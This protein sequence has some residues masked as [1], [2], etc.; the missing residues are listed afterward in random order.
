MELLLSTVVDPIITVCMPVYNNE[1]YFTE[2]IES[3]LSQG[4]KEIQIIVA[5]DASTDRT[6]KLAKEY[7]E[8]YPEIIDL[9][10]HEK[11]QGVVGNVDSIYPYIR[12]KYICWFAGDDSFLPGKLQKQLEFMESNQE[13]VMCYHDMFTQNRETGYRYR[14][15]DPLIGVKAYSGQVAGM[16]IIGP[17]F[18]PTMS[19]MIRRQGTEQIKHRKEVGILNDWLYL[20]ELA[21]SGP[22]WQLDEPLGIYYKHGDSV[23]T[24]MICS[25]EHAESLYKFLNENYKS[26]GYDYDIQKGRA[27]SYLNY[28][29]K[30]LLARQPRKSILMLKQLLSLCRQEKRLISFIASNTV[31]RTIRH[32]IILLKIGKVCR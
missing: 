22:V 19:M 29:F 6:S 9:I 20:I 14:Y 25:H 3:V 7:K 26:A 13:Y 21:I 23:T 32:T 16:L 31:D 18:V 10:L 5:D 2:A 15:N 24:K 12:G 17:P 8:K 28:I 27:L 11:N 4:P 1:K 30:Y